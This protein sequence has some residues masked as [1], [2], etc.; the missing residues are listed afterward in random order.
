MDDGFTLVG[1]LPDAAAAGLGTQGASPQFANVV[2]RVVSYV[3][4]YFA[5][6]EPLAW[7]AA[8]G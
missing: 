1:E 3:R 5:I 7:R 8:S 6:A 2:D 4:Q